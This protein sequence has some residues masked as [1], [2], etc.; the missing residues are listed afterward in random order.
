LSL[1]SKWGQKEHEKNNQKGN[2]IE[3][4]NQYLSSEWGQKGGDASE[5]SRLL[6]CCSLRS[7]ENNQYLLSLSS[8]WGQKEH[9]KN[10]QKG[11]RRIE[12]NNQYLSSE[13]GQKGG[14]ASEA[15]RL[16]GCCSLR[17]RETINICCLCRE[18]ARENNQYLLSLKGAERALV[19]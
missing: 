2:R 17:S 11:N 14:D 15:S 18:E 3:K 4:N 6:G 8:K 5:A 19:S 16:L 13:W 7:R 1:S 9:E 12:K 10:N